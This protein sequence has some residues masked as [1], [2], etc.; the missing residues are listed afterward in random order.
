MSGQFSLNDM[1]VP[2]KTDHVE[3]DKSYIS[4]WFKKKSNGMASNNCLSDDGIDA[5]DLKP[6]EDQFDE[7][8]MIYRLVGQR[9]I[10]KGQALK[11]K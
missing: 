8:N 5:N 7:S 9:I 11:Q 2:L 6:G 10:R 4:P 3:D 1:A